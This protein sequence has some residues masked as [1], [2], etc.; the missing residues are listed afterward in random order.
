MIKVLIMLS[1]LFLISCGGDGDSLNF[2]PAR[3]VS[4]CIPTGVS[5]SLT[6][7]T[8]ATADFASITDTE[9]TYTTGD[10]TGTGTAQTPE[11]DNDPALTFSG[12]DLGGGVSY[13]SD[14]DDMGV[15][16]FVPFL[17]RDGTLYVGAAS[18]NIDDGASVV[19]APFIAA[20]TTSATIIFTQQ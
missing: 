12:E 16:E 7:T 17:Y 19:F 18:D 5:T 8:E 13:F 20:P 11:V 14:K 2:P 9:T 15:T 4:S 10:C 3:Y 6:I 1:A